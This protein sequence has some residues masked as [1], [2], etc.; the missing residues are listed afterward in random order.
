MGVREWISGSEGMS[1][2]EEGMSGR[3]G[4]DEWEGGR[5]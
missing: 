5:G 4:G 2:S 3:E 1:G